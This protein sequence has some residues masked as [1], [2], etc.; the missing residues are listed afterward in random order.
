[1]DARLR[2]AGVHNKCCGIL[3][4]VTWTI[5]NDSGSV[6]DEPALAKTVEDSRKHCSPGNSAGQQCF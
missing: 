6:G 4:C 3:D 1:M 2:W 5:Q